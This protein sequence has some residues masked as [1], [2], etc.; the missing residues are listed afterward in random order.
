MSLSPS[1]L[2]A[3]AALFDFRSQIVKAALQILS[4]GGITAY[5]PGQGVQ[6]VG[7]YFVSVDFQRAGFT[8]N[9]KSPLA[10]DLGAGAGRS[11]MYCEF[12][13]TLSIMNS[14]PY[15]TDEK[16][17]AAYLLEDHVR[18]LDELTSTELALFMEPL[19]PFTAALL[20]NLDIMQLLPI[21][22]DERPPSEREV[23][24]AFTRWFIRA[25]IRPSAWPT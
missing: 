22:P 15:E 21:E 11:R 16:T 5:G 13:G 20:P 24:V 25:S 12:T 3:H 9:V 8:D 7:R 1:Q 6:E 2:S 14:V 18:T 10:L 17:S 19:Q 4:A 23:N